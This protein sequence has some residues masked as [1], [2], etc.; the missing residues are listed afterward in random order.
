MKKP[1][2][3]KKE[4]PMD[5]NIAQ[6][7]DIVDLS[8]PVIMSMESFSDLKSAASV[9]DDGMRWKIIYMYLDLPSRNSNYYPIDDTRR[10]MEESS[11]VQE[12]LRNHTWY[13]EAEHPPADAPLSRFLFIEPTRYAWNILTHSFAGD[14]FEGIVSLC[15]PLG[16]SIILPNIKAFG[17]NYA[18]SCRIYTPNFVEKQEGGRKIV[19]K[20]Y[21]M[22]PCT[23]DCVTMP[24]Y[25]KCRVADPL[26]YHPENPTSVEST[27]FDVKFD[28]PASEFI[29]M[30]SSE[31][32][33]IL[34]DYFG[35]DF[36]KHAVIMKDNKVKLSTEDGLSVITSLDSYLLSNALK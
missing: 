22:Y 12:N 26:T 13:G 34:E 35:V 23:Y 1:L 24:G 21:K 11:F 7:R 30:M 6:Q 25:A 19:I 4:I 32:Y 29:K 31:N 5:F 18:S 20:K 33:K 28:N 15:A 8:K 36:R 2:Y 9:S 14:H 17:S 27:F 10:S 16:T 3:L